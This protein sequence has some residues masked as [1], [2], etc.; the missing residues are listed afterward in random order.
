MIYAKVV[1]WGAE[2]SQWKRLQSSIYH[3]APLY[4]SVAQLE[5]HQTFNLGVA[6]SI[7]AGE[8]TTVM[9]LVL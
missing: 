4:L 1:A 8:T 2:L 7:P 6:G 3:Q 5:E 9:H